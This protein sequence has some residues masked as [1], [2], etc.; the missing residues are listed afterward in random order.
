MN[1]KNKFRRLIKTIVIAFYYM[2]VKIMSV[3]K[4]VILFESN[5]GRNYTGNPRAI[6][7]EMVR[8]GLDHK[9]VCVWFF[10]N[11]NFT[12]LGNAKIVKRARIKYL[13]YMAIGGIWV[14]DCR[15]PEF[16]IKRE[17]TRYIQTW[18]GT[19]LKKL[20]LD[21]EQVD[22]I[23][24]NSIEQYHEEFRK[25]T[26]T[27]D[28]LISQNH[29][30]TQIFRRCF[31]F[32]NK[33]I[34]EIGYPRNDILFH[35]NSPKDILKIKEKYGLPT[36]KKLILYAPTWRDNEFY[37]QGSYKFSSRLDFDMARKQLGDKYVFL[38]KY[39]YLVADKIDW[40]KYEGFVFS[41]DEKADISRLYLIADYLVTDYSS[42]MFDYS[43]LQRPIFFFAYDLENYKDNLRGFYFDFLK[44][45]PGPI[46]RST[47]QLVDDIQNY[48]PQNWKE[49]YQKFSMK[50]N[51]VD[52]GRAS[53]KIVD[54]IINLTQI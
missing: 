4:N 34:L 19:P 27:W 46:S 48:Q 12:V 39:H 6:Y 41:F 20:A 54:L 32:E 43:I 23:V 51:H 30:S 16:L 15:Q 1:M 7:E 26:S 29:F 5:L 9:Y 8:Q 31:A 2:I 47:E 44:E 45:V 37:D 17:E 18:H 3:K 35:K 52:D 21:M 28:Y 25:N 24:S 13:Y 42:V 14:F 11:P 33:P 50:Y 10:E 40:S 36:N 38:V 49:K 22:T 53:E